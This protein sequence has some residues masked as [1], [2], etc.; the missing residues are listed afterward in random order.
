MI[1]FLFF[2]CIYI[3]TV[4]LGIPL[5][6]LVVQSEVIFLEIEKLRHLHTSFF[7]ILY[8]GHTYTIYIFAYFNKKIKYFFLQLRKN[9]QKR[10]TEVR[11]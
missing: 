7:V 3:Q 4:K 11:L 8:T 9:S 5:D 10:R 1:L 6:I 2:F